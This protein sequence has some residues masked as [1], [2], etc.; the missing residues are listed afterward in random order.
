MKRRA[1]KHHGHAGREFVRKLL[2]V[3]D[4]DRPKMIK[5]IE[6]RRSDYVAK[7][8]KKVTTKGR[9]LTRIHGKFATIYAAGALASKFKVLPLSRKELLAA[10]LKCEKDHVAFVAREIDAPAK[11]TANSFDR[12]LAYIRENQ[13]GFVDLRGGEGA[14]TYNVD[15]S[16]GYLN[17]HKGKLEFL[18]TEET[19]ER[20]AGGKA[21][22]V[23][24]KRELR[25]RK[26]IVTT[27]AGGQTVKFVVRR[28]LGDAKRS[29]VV[30][31]DHAILDADRL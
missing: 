15:P 28:R 27:G 6:R 7:A 23:E 9:D 26:L 8:K 30:A 1:V 14:S 31:V 19:F 20:I 5:W 24:L 25:R 16:L 22:A 11:P 10:I 13:H 3:P 21:A 4:V 29:T 18:L 12:L 2:A 17:E